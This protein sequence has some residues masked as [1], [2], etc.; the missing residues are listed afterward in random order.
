VRAEEKVDRQARILE[1]VLGLLARQ[2]IS[3]V[4]M[5]SVAR[6]ANVALGLVNYHYADKTS[7]I[8]AALRRIEEQDG[9][10]RGRAVR[11]GE[12]ARAPARQ[13]RRDALLT[14]IVA[15]THRDR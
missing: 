4:S 10:R 7:L 6:E 15:A 3:G 5:R 11:T 9:R 14:A 12:R 2:G 1:A 8:G 13:A